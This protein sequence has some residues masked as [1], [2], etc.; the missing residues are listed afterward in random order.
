M[1]KFSLNSKS[2]QDGHYK[3]LSNEMTT[4]HNTK[5]I[6]KFILDKYIGIRLKKCCVYLLSKI[7]IIRNLYDK[8]LLLLLT[9]RSSSSLL[10]VFT[11]L[12]STSIFDQYIL[13]YLGFLKIESWIL[14]Y[15]TY[16]SMAMVKASIH[17][18]DMVWCSY[19]AYVQL[20]IAFS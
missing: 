2:S 9:F 19:L 17:A 10:S 13:L 1:A 5:I 12:T 8:W 18:E 14:F 4:L 15:L 6:N 7:L 20:I 3:G 11:P 16:L